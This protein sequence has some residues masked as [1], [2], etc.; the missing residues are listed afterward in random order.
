MLRLLCDSEF[1]FGLHDPGGEQIMLEASKPGWVL[2]TEKIGRNPNDRGGG[3]YASYAEKGLGVMVRL[4]H[5]YEPE[6]TIP[7]SRYYEDFAKRCANFVAASFGCHTWIIGNEMNFVVERPQLEGR[8]VRKST[9]PE[10]RGPDEPPYSPRERDDR[11]NVLHPEAA[12]AR[13][14]RSAEGREV[15]TPQLYARCYRLC[16]DAIHS[17]RGHERIRCWWAAWLPG[18]TRRSTKAIP[19]A[20]GCAISKTF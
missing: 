16:R 9:P 18:T 11:F 4:N 3:N 20:T 1:I 13:Q 2:F 17:V 5:G 19:P 14:T 15:I 8:A 7:L 12:G 6:G 10:S